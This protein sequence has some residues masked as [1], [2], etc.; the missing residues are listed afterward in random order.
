MQSEPSYAIPIALIPEGTDDII[1]YIHLPAIPRGGEML[2]IFLPEL[3][4]QAEDQYRV[5]V[6]SV[7]YAA[8]ESADSSDIPA[9]NRSINQVELVIAPLDQDSADIIANKLRNRGYGLTSRDETSPQETSPNDGMRSRV[10]PLHRRKPS[11]QGS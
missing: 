7:S 8:I 3:P 1:G 10:L 9:D 4:D 11:G 6:V 5:R 2:Y